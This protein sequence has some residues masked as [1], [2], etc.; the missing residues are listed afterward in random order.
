MKTKRTIFSLIVF[1][2][3]FYISILIGFDISMNKKAYEQKNEN[4]HIYV[5]NTG[6]QGAYESRI[7]SLSNNYGA[8]LASTSGRLYLYEESDADNQTDQGTSKADDSDEHM[9]LKESVESD[10]TISEEEAEVN[11][12]AVD[13]AGIP[14]TIEEEILQD[15]EPNNMPSAYADIGISIANNYV[16]IR[17]KATTESEINGKLY[18]NSAARILDTIG[19]WYYVESGGVMGYIKTDYLKT[20]LS[21]EELVENYGTLRVSINTDG[22][23]VREAP[24]IEAKKLTVVYNNE[25]YPVIELYD[26]WLKIDITDDRI[27][28][29]VSKEYVELL[30]AFEKAISKEEEEELKK[31]QEEE[32]IK[33]ETEVKYRDEVDY[34]QDE[35]KL[36]ACLVHAEA[37]NQCYEGKLAVANVVLNRVKTSKYPN[38]INDVIYQ[39]GQFTVARTGSL[40]KQLD[41][42]EDYST[43]SQQLTIKAAK[44]ALSGANNIGSRLYFHA[45]KLAVSKGY[46]KKKTSVKIEDHLF[47]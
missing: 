36:L 3:I 39:P 23:N 40:A 10:A 22:L 24:D 2:S 14:D 19:D 16:N 18:K 21:D 17:D 46:D 41:R 34:T 27:I 45:Y 6:S 8:N 4:P 47:W 43:K 25:I 13:V 1:L 30:V 11:D 35:L 42:Y 5:D 15:E 37:G 9:P 32:R 31:L 12:D 7:N 29:Y 26:E 28:G 38:S 44:A 33:K 20:G